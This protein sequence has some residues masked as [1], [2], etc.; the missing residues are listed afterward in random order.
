[1]RIVMGSYRSLWFIRAV[2]SMRMGDPKQIIGEMLL[3]LELGKDAKRMVRKA[4]N[5]I[6]PVRAGIQEP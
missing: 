4:I 1:M 2:F 6:I 5:R 3:S